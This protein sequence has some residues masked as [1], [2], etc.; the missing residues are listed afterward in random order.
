MSDTITLPDSYEKEVILLE[1]I[2]NEIIDEGMKVRREH[3]L[4]YTD[5]W[6]LVRAI[7]NK[8]IH[9]LKTTN[10]EVRDASPHATNNTEG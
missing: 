5:D 9:E 3:G 7:V 8:T 2:T 10:N 4:S 6:N 1:Y